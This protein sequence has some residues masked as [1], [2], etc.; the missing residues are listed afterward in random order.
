MPHCPWCERFV[1]S[2]DNLNNL[3]NE[4]YNIDEENK[5]KVVFM[6]VNGPDQHELASRY[7]VEGYP[8]FIYLTPGKKG[9]K[10]KSYDG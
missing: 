5:N 1:G 9:M 10:A 7:R 4:T 6:M 3:F 2:W 8:E